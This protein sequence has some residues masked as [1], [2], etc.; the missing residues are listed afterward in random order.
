MGDP[1]LSE[2]EKTLMAW[3]FVSPQKAALY[4]ALFPGKCYRACSPQEKICRCLLKPRCSLGT[5]WERHRSDKALLAR[6]P[7]LRKPFV[8][9]TPASKLRGF[10][11]KR[12]E[13]P[14]IIVF[15]A[16][17]PLRRISRKCGRCEKYSFPIG[18]IPMSSKVTG[19]V[20]TP[21]EYPLMLC[22]TKASQ[23]IAFQ[24]NH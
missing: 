4:K 21:R 15:G 12:G 16:L 18:P 10:C 5:V 7:W 19:F 3:G 23:K 6:L 9:V 20:T 22:Q 8:Y 1:L 14:F 2:S 13:R 17:S 11:L 24:V